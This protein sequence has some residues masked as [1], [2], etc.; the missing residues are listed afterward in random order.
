MTISLRP[1]Q[2]KAKDQARARLACGIRRLLVCAPTGA[3]KTVLFASI[4]LSA[5]AKGSRVLILAHRRELLK[6]PFCK[7]IR[8]GLDPNLVGVVLAGVEAG[9]S[10]AI[11]GP[12]DDAD[13]NTLWRCFA[14]RRSNAPVQIASIDSIRNRAKPPAYLII[15]DEAHRTLAAG[16]LRLADE[17]PDAVFIGLTATPLRADNKPLGQFFE[18]MVIVATYRELVAEG[19]LVEPR[20][21]TVPA[22]ELP[23]LTRVRIKGGDYDAEQLSHVCDQK[24][25]VGSITDHW[26]RHGNNAPTFCFGVN[27]EH[28]KHIV[29][30]FAQ[31]GI[32]AA[33]VDGST[34]SSERDEAIASLKAGRIK[35]LC[36]VD[37]ATEGI[38]VPCVK[39]VILARPTK[40]LRVFLQQ[41]GR[42]SRP[43]KS[44]LPFVI[45]DHAGAVIEHGLP[46]MVE[47]LPEIL[48]N[49]K[50]K[51]GLKSAPARSCPSCWA[52]VS[53]SCKACP[54][55]GHE[56]ASAPRGGPE[57][58][59]G[60][61][62]EVCAPTD[63]DL[64]SAWEKIREECV[65]KGYQPGWLSVRWNELFPGTN[66]PAGCDAPNAEECSQ[67]K[68]ER[69]EILDEYVA[70]ALTKGYTIGW[71]RS[72]FRGRTGQFPSNEMLHRCK[73]VET[74][75]AWLTGLGAVLKMRAPRAVALVVPEPAN[76]VEYEV[77]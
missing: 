17:Y 12:I 41:V 45:L 68:S 36:N 55:C 4:V 9:P 59:E 47:F 71:V 70:K 23:D 75:R 72:S 2:A 63:T 6:Q 39:T 8:A 44:G 28:S 50:N 43:D 38:D 48:H 21:Y 30:Q 3:G 32:A 33:H 31:A 69:V 25:L 37:V 1:Y 56:F 20:V 16:Y 13:D 61:L 74:V 67:R 58:H 24:G 73:S 26:K 14:R 76:M 46:H 29:E 34:P 53:A 42:G 11:L 65:D 19:F 35:V 66:P 7:F 18:D 49:T 77:A 40:S 64:R 51:S 5:V 10:K 52:V 62:V 27:V 57:E 60:E 15:I 22:A 54:D